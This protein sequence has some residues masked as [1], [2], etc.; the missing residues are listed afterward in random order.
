MLSSVAQAHADQ[1]PR[2]LTWR[3]GWRFLRVKD[4]RQVLSM[5]LVVIGVGFAV[6]SVLCSV[7]AFAVVDHR[8]ERTAS[9]AFLLSKDPGKAQA[10]VDV[11]RMPYGDRMVLRVD[12]ALDAN[13]P[14]LPPGVARWPA[15]GER[16]VSPAFRSA[17][18]HNSV[19]DAYAPGRIVGT[20]GEPGLRSPDELV[21][22]RGVDRSAL[23][24][25]GQAVVARHGEPATALFLDSIEIPGG[26][27]A[28]LVAVVAVCLGLPLVAFLSIAARLSASTR[29]RRLATLHLLGV[30]ARS[31]RAINAVE[32]LLLSLFGAG[33]ALAA[34]PLVNAILAG[35]N[36]VGI[37]WFPADTALSPI[38]A[39]FVVVGVVLLAGVAAR[40]VDY[41]ADL[42]SA[43]TR[44]GSR[45]RTTSMWQLLP[46][47]TG[48]IALIAQVVSGFIRPAGQPAFLH[49]D[50]VMLFAVLVTGVGVL[51]SINPMTRAVGRLAHQFGHSLAIRIG[52]ARA[53]FDPAATARLVAGLAIL[54]FAVGVT[55]GQTRDARAV[56][57]PTGP[58]VDIDVNVDDLPST[59]SA[60]ALLDIGPAPG[61]AQVSTDPAIPAP[62]Q[63]T[64]ADCTQISRFLGA[65]PAGFAGGCKP[66]TAYWAPTFSRPDR[67]LIKLPITDAQKATITSSTMP[68]SLAALLDTTDVLITFPAATIIT[69]DKSPQMNVP[70][71]G[72]T[73]TR[74]SDAK[75]IVLRTSPEAV[76][77]TLAHVYTV[78]P[79][80]Q[81]SALGLDPDSGE[82]IAMINGYIRLGLLGGTLM[83]LLALTAALADR[84]TERRRADHELLA[85]GA[86]RTLVRRAH[87][88]EVTLILITA[89]GVASTAGILGGLAWQ[90]AGGL[91]RTPDW[92]SIAVL[93]IM[94]AAVSGLATLGAAVAAPR[95][96]EL[97][98]LRRG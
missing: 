9:R 77:A 79:Y 29:A 17:I 97:T 20:V 28:A 26:Q 84:A 3:L 34:Y 68:P 50:L 71:S 43:R 49:L 39:A 51:L 92:V 57:V 55:I 18:A 42:T 11:H 80:S 25:G 81:P 37:T 88:W 19:L 56:S 12:V 61:V 41:G 86:P 76:N 48:L 7:A 63:A 47:I 24:R 21:V 15:P 94:A 60:T 85:S 4:R 91:D 31:V 65:T 98:A 30:P 8:A 2:M 44:R 27:I 62:I 66:G 1:V 93:L 83:A 35:S 54:V 95:R 58:S 90:L 38:T 33:W 82:H 13:P 64:V 16:V 78:A 10:W 72:L 69:T 32:I 40:R 89:L 45:A 67:S 59:A 36:I 5:I 73:S 53:A 96:L 46:L 6:L 23:P 70:V 75:Q 52:G 87:R 14:L 22:Y 74:Y